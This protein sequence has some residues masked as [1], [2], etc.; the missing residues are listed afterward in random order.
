MS[1]V[2][3]AMRRTLLSCTSLARHGLLGL[4]SALLSG[5]TASAA[6]LS[7]AEA[8]ALVK[9]VRASAARGAR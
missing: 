4:A 7:L 5:G 2:V 8:V 3:A 9:R 1:G 6:E